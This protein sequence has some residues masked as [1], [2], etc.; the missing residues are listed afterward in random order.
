MENGSYYGIDFGTTNTSVC[1]Y[2]YEYGVGS[3]LSEYGT[4]GENLT[5]FS[6]CIAISKNIKNDFKYGREVKENINKYSDD[7]IIVNSFKSLL[8]TDKEIPVCGE[9]YNG[10]KLTAL[11]L[12]HV[13]ETF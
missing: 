10:K 2:H 11:F 5:P 7:Y 8:G 1:L 13:K 12:N 9:R 3:K 6:S 4:N